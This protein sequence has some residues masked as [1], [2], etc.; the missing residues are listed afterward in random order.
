METAQFANFRVTDGDS[1]SVNQILDR[2]ENR[3]E[4]KGAVYHEGLLAQ[5]DEVNSVKKLIDKAEGIMGD[6]FLNR[7]EITRMHEDLAGDYSVDLK[8][9]LKGSTAD[10][11]LQKNDVL[12]IPSIHDL[13]EAGVLTIHGRLRFRESIPMPKMQE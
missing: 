6:A 13:K 11:P 10:I 8:G 1:L 3:V 4:I 7:A 9:I 5:R 12:Y 2:F